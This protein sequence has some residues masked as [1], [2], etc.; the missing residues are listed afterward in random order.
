MGC[1]GKSNAVMIRYGSIEAGIIGLEDVFRAV[2]A[3]G[4]TDEAALKHEL[5]TRI[6]QAGNYIAPSVE[7]LYQEALLHEYNSY[8]HRLSTN[9]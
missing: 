6:R 8:V 7:N 9:R 3:S 1:C 4:I 2:A 5:V